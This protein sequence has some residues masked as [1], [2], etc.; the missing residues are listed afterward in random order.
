MCSLN[1][2]NKKI[3]SLLLL[4]IVIASISVASA[5]EVNQ[6]T[7][8]FPESQNSAVYEDSLNDMQTA[9]TF[10]DL[11][12]KINSNDNSEIYL[13]HNYTFNSDFDEEFK[14]GIVI[15]RAITVWGNGFTLDGNNSARIFN[16][17]NSNVVFHDINFINGNTADNGG[18]I[19][20][21]CSAANC[22]FT[23]NTAGF[24][25]AVTGTDCVNCRFTQNSA[26]YRGG[27]SCGGSFENCIFTGN[28]AYHEGGAYYLGSNM[29]IYSI[30]NCS[31][32]ENSANEGGA[33]SIQFPEYCRVVDCTFT[34]NTASWIAGAVN[35]VICENCTFIENS[36]DYGGAMRYGW[37]INCIFLGNSAIFGGASY[38]GGCRNSTFIE[39]YADYG[40]AIYNGFRTENCMFIENHA[41]YGGAI[42][43]NSLTVETCYFAN[44]TAI[45]GGALYQTE[46]KNSYFE[47]NSAT[48]MGG[49]IYGETATNCV[50]KNNSRKDTYNCKIT[51]SDANITHDDNIIYFDASAEDD[52]NG[53][54]KNPYKY[55][56]A[57]RITPG[58]TAYFAQGTY[59]LEITCTISQAK[60]I[61][62]GRAVISSKVSDKYDFIIRQNSYLE[63]YNLILN[64]VNILNQA[65][66]KADTCSFEGNDVFDPQNLPEIESGSGLF[67]SSYGGVIVCDTPGDV[68]STLILNGCYFQRVY[69]AFNGGVIAAI[70]SNISISNT[71]FMHYSATY[72][73]GAI[74]CINSNLNMHNVQFSAFTSSS[75]DDA[76][77]NRYGTYTAYYGGSIY[78]ENSNVMIYQ[79]KFDDSVSFSF[80]GSIASLNSHITI[81]ESS[82]NNSKS[83]TDGGG[84]VYNSKSELHIFNSDIHGNSAEFGGAI[85]NINSVLDSYRSRYGHNHATHYGGVIY[86]IYGTLNVYLNQ[87]YVS[88]AEIGGVIYTRIPNEYNLES[89]SFGDAF[90]NEGAAIF[91]DGKKQ[92]VKPNYFG[93][94]YYA[95]AEFTASLNG[96]DYYIISNPIFYQL[97][98]TATTLYFPYPVYEVYDSMVNMTIYDTDDELKLTSVITDEIKH[99]ISVNIS[100]TDRLVNP[101]LNVY[102]FEDIDISL[103][104]KGLPGNLYTGSRNNLFEGHTL[105]GNYSIDLSDM[106]NSYTCTIDFGNSFLSTK[107]DN[108]YEASSFNPVSLINS[109]FADFT[110]L[111][112]EIEV[113]SSY[114]NSNDYGYVSSVKDQKDG[115]NCWAFSGIATLETCLSKATGVSYDF[116][117]ENAKNLM[118]AYS[119]Y[120]MKLETNYAGYESMILSYLTSWIG[121]IDES[122]EDYDDY[123]SISVLQNPM[124]HIQNVKF[125]P[126]RA[127]SSDNYMYKMAIR[128]NG[129]VSVTFKWGNDYHSVSLV[130]WDDNYRG[131]DSLGNPSNGAWIFKNSWGPDWENGGFGYLSYDEKISEQIYPN[132]HAY[133][134]VFSDV[135]P[136]TKIYQYD[137]AGVSEF[138]HYMDTISFK[139]TFK[140]DND[141]IL[142]AFSTYFDRL[143]NFTVSVYKNGE[144]A[145][146][147]DGTSSAGYS[148]IAFNTII[149]LDEGDEFT[150]AVNNH[151]KGYNCIPVCSA[152]EI[153]KKTF[154]RNV[155]FISLDGE[156]WFDLYDYA[157]SCHVACIKAFTQNVN[158]EDITI[159]INEFN[160]V[161][162]N[163]FNI[164]VEFSDVNVDFI[165]YCLVKFKID[166]S[167]YYAQ[168]RNGAAILNV[169]LDDGY[170]TLSAQYK[171][172]LFESNIVTFNFTVKKN[173]DDTSF[174]AIQDLINNAKD[175]VS[176]DKDYLYSEKFD[177]GEYG[178]HVN[179]SLTINGNGHIING[180]G[181]AAGFYIDADNVVLNDIIFS[182]TQSSNGGGIFIAAK[183]V[184][185][186]NCSFIN[187]HALQNGGGIYSLFD[188]T[189][190]NCRFINNSAKMGAGLYLISGKSTYIID[191]HFEAN[192]ADI[193]GSAVYME[194][195]GKVMFTSTNF[196]GNAAPYNGGAVMSSAYANTFENCSFT[197]N[198]ANSGGAVF[199]NAYINEFLNCSFENNTA[200][201]SGGAISS[202]N[203]I[204]IYDSS[205]INNSVTGNDD[206]YYKNPFGGYG[207]G[208]VYSYDN[209]N[210]YRSD[211]IN[212]S[213]ASDSGGALYTSKYLNIYDS[214]FI[215]NTS[216][217]SGGA[218]YNTEW[219][220]IRTN[221]GMSKFTQSR[222][223][224]S[225]FIGN[226]ASSGGA[227][228]KSDLIVNCTFTNNSATG[229]GGAVN[230]VKVI[231]SSRFINNTATHAGAVYND[232]TS[233]FY[234][235]N[236]DFTH[237]HAQYGG[238][239]YSHEYESYYSRFISNT[240]IND[241]R[242]AENTADNVG[243]CIYSMG[244]VNVNHTEFRNNSAIYGGAVYGNDEINIIKSIFTDNIAGQSGGAVYMSG[245]GN[246]TVI[247]CE[248]TNNTS[249]FGG[250]IFAL[251]NAEISYSL[252]KDNTGHSYGGAI[253]FYKNGTYTLTASSFEANSANYGGAIYIYA[254]DE[255]SMAYLNV[256]KC[257][258]T[259]NNALRSG[260]AFY[261][262]AST[263]IKESN[264]TN[265]TATWGSALYSTG[266]ISVD[267]TNITSGQ[268]IPV[269]EYSYHYSDENPAY[270]KLDLKNN[271]IDV[272]G[273]IV[274]YNVNGID[275]SMLLYLVFANLNTVKGKTVSICRLEDDEG[276]SVYTTGLGKLNI[277]LTD[278]SK[279]R[280]QLLLNYSKDYEGY[281]LD[282]SS[283]DYGTYTISGT[284]TN[285]QLKYSTKPAVLQITDEF[286][287]TAP[288]IITA[289][290]TK[291]YGKS[292]K[293][294]ITLKDS[295]G[296][297]I[298]D[299][300]LSVKINGKTTFLVTDSKGHDSMK[301]N[302]AP[303]TYYAQISFED[304]GYYTS[305]HTTVK[306]TVKKATPKLTAK[307]K[308][309]KIKAKSKKYTITLKN[310]LGK[311]MKKVK[312][313]IKVKGKTYTAKTNSKGI[314]TFKL[315]LTKKGTFKATVTYKGSKYY[316]KVSKKVKITFK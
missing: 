53:S 17:A 81:K 306:V 223:Y 126:A 47:N 193:H 160:T 181:K 282:T 115:G 68:K 114:Y 146:S 239:I 229:T 205:F 40:G 85:C 285:D 307:K 304:N 88:R 124:F 38:E 52:G 24:G 134:F 225:L 271:T 293:L 151:N 305:A 70:N 102:L 161:N 300:P 18:A 314:A 302:L 294:V 128:D 44:N 256:S 113:L 139:N 97:S 39:N 202:H 273:E 100:F 288:A 254:P 191:S 33:I 112:S 188:I 279:N 93:N 7:E 63:L 51:E 142:S 11:N 165:N 278:Q 77:V 46:V 143:T 168:I 247:N 16:V 137:F 64:N 252:F 234:V 315:K 91:Y 25:G 237:N 10:S 148:T 261:S 125:L 276:N 73:G 280:I 105:I 34:A 269:I 232:G 57:E 249:N 187:S 58:V 89:N 179:R 55:L 170:H 12:S 182:N 26:N 154:S 220:M 76:T 238:A 74:Y 284:L 270:G 198:Y 199:S 90:A 266:Y 206:Q 101:K 87:F 56:Y 111:P 54:K 107:Y 84:A 207:G 201:N 50:F 116:S 210:I 283:L 272:K 67:D 27:A 127:D 184:T 75:D 72:K 122:N 222:Y 129:A 174:N 192:T 173:D 183:N 149:Q 43:G 131:Y 242:F 292:D 250:A 60:L 32:T 164:R 144:F 197:D 49:A 78:C 213:A 244:K 35:S 155:S 257:N 157:D 15:D 226:K 245:N 211:F 109:S 141:S 119:V 308:T 147:Q 233:E 299:A 310:N 95:F 22:N 42:H 29:K 158:L 14:K 133:T 106:I 4:L 172:N 171:D 156:T 196:T 121:P 65:T 189:L 265:N 281:Y 236:S 86:D 104:K 36:A 290:L 258:F 214:R 298:S 176:L 246:H 103:Y 253:D 180:L 221:S 92:D 177:D 178:V 152:E 212:N 215:N 255:E 267:N 228:F 217:E 145:F 251:N 190:N 108:I 123:S 99:R 208:A 163:N 224:N 286:G 118:A 96:E 9:R 110:S 274:H 166:N 135:N 296:N 150:I 41:D 313:T 297:V 248:F 235:F 83:I 30:T 309:F 218:I 200:K 71:V 159:K 264:L 243:G 120:G 66:L 62:T 28:F 230:E 130:G 136:Y 219:Q 277:T 3:F 204:N 311:V 13:K 37:A 260:G 19:N 169:N 153:T 240:I 262:D 301:I 8:T 21:K 275:S 203:K 162:T 185:L 79:S 61:G 45:D 48:G 80:G 69:D 303:N 209:L 1:I 167:T 316:N 117:E 195:L 23:R 20:G 259:Q 132:L 291:V 289:A 312:V 287:R 194:G 263:K 268:D 216:P 6:T 227:I 175:T 98:S 82:L 231:D 140:A 186:N 31:F 59:E 94:D 138:Y 295:T 2:F 5:N 241:S